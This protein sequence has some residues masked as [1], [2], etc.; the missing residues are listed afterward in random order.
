MLLCSYAPLTLSYPMLLRSYATVRLQIR[1]C[2]VP[3]DA[4]K[5]G[6][7]MFDDIILSV[8]LKRIISD[9]KYIILSDVL[10][11]TNINPLAEIFARC[12]DRIYERHAY[13]LIAMAKGAHEIRYVSRG[14]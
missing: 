1:D 3:Q 14:I 5:E 11:I 12:I 7:K 9:F 10:S 4:E 2:P 13:T 8:I 6:T